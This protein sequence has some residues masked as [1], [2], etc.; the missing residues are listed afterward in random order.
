MINEFYEDLHLH[1]GGGQ[2]SEL[3][4]PFEMI[5]YY[6]ECKCRLLI[7]HHDKNKLE[8]FIHNYY[9]DEPD[10]QHELGNMCVVHLLKEQVKRLIEMLQKCH[11]NMDSTIKEK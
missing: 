3:K 8:M 7:S 2:D 4:L 1:G 5:N 10:D 6:D 9:Y 11:D